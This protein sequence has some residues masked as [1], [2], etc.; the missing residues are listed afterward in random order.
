MY[1]PIVTPEIVMGIGILV[2]FS[3]LFGWINSVLALAAGSAAVD[4]AGHRHR[5]A[6]CLQRAVCHPGRARAAARL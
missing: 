2:L 1:F 5:V 3:A 4:G 6:H